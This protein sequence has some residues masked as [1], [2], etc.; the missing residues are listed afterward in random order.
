MLAFMVGGI[1]LF[2]ILCFGVMIVGWLTLHTIPG[3]GIWPVALGVIYV[4]PPIA[5]VLMLT[6][7]VVIAVRK[8]REHRKEA[9]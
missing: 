5:I 8:A 7:V 1:I 9:R 2:T 3:N 4:G 6:M